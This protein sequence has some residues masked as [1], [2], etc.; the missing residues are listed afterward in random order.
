M[1]QC[2][3]MECP[4]TVTAIKKTPRKCPETIDTAYRVLY[5]HS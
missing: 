2:A 4:C 3:G 5:N 1:L